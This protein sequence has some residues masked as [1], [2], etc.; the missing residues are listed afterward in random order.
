MKPAQ[1]PTPPPAPP[2]PRFAI[3]TLVDGR[4][5]GARLR[6]V[7]LAGHRFVRCVVLSTRS[8]T[9]DCAP[10]QVATVMWC[11][12]DEARAA[13]PA[14]VTPAELR[15]AEAPT[16]PPPRDPA[17]EL[18]EVDL[19]EEDESR[20]WLAL[21]RAQS[22][23]IG[24][25]PAELASDLGAEDVEIRAESVVFRVAATDEGR[26]R[27]ALDARGLEV[28]PVCA[29]CGCSDD[30]RCEGGCAWASASRSLCDR[31]RDSL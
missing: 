26:V 25:S 16:A 13:C 22:R 10:S 28:A 17:P 29:R 6:E 1:I 30:R 15:V 18:I 23:S 8:F 4:R 12:L 11:S 19:E 21:S 7:T 31:C 9:L 24:V 27:A 14:E 5:F 2:P 3:V 20:V